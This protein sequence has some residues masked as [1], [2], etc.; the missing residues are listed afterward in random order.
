LKEDS[1]LDFGLTP[2]ERRLSVERGRIPGVNCHPISLPIPSSGPQVQS[3]AEEDSNLIFAF[4]GF[5]GS[6]ASTARAELQPWR[7]I[8]DRSIAFG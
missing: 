5:P 3:T 6:E 8:V 1:D 7:S 4:A 2:G